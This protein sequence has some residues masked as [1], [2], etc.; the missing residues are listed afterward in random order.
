MKQLALILET[1]VVSLGLFSWASAAEVSLK[2]SDKA[3]PKEAGDSIRKALQPKSI[4][5]L[6]AEKPIFDFWFRSELPLK[7]KPE[8][9]AKSLDSIAE[10]TLIGVAMVGEGRRDYKDNEIVAGTYTIRFGLQPQDGDH[11]G[12]S[13]FPYFAVLIPVA[14]DPEIESITKFKAMTK[15]S[16]KGTSAGHPVVLSLRPV[17]AEAGDTPLITKPAPEHQAIRLRLTGKIAGS[18]QPVPIS[19]ELVFQ[20]KYKS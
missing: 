19:F 4:Q 15:A 14:S 5:L 8:S 11:L 3:P 9:P 12:T 13:E 10:I 16:S 17:S 18:D 1:A 6:E 2:I 7:S 20:G